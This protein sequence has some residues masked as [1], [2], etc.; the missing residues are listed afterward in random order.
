MLFLRKTAFHFFP[1]CSNTRPA[2]SMLRRCLFAQ[3][4]P[5]GGYRRFGSAG[6]W[7]AGLGEIA[8]AAA[9]FAAELFGRPPDK[10]HRI[11]TLGQILRHADD[12]AG[13]AVAAYADDRH[14]PGAERLL[15]LVGKRFQ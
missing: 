4:I 11:E 5:N 15:G 2:Y 3:S 6:L 14:D 7:T 1:A 10:L 13:L 8:A 9:A 12:D